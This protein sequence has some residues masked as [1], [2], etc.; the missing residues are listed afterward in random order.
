[1]SATAT[2]VRVAPMN[3]RLRLAVSALLISWALSAIF[4]VLGWK[5]AR[6]EAIE[7]TPTTIQS[8][9]TPPVAPREA[10]F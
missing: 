9:S 8:V 1:M 7:T 4:I 6:T 2:V 5:E 3:L 10:K